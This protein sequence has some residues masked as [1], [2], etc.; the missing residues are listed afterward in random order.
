MDLAI[1]TPSSL[2]RYQREEKLW[3]SDLSHLVIDEADTLFDRSF[4]DETLEIIK[5]V[6]LR[7]K[8]PSATPAISKDAQV[9]VVGATLSE[10][11][12]KKMDSLIPASYRCLPCRIY[13]FVVLQ[14]LR[15]V[16]TKHV[17]TILPHIQQTFVKTAQ[18]EKAE[19]LLSLIQS[20]PRDVFMVFC[21]TVPSCDWTARYLSDHNVP[22]IKLHGGFAPQVSYSCR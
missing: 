2:L 5:T 13:V 11:V 22:V 17:H 6:K 9:T 4:R 21:N 19:Q 12:L 3:L 20:S 15:R 16:S 8:K 14:N 7:S 18:N 10:A 1:A